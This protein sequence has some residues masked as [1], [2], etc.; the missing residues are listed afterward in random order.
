MFWRLK[1]NERTINEPAFRV[2]LPGEWIQE[3]S[4]A[5]NLWTYHAEGQREGLTISIMGDTQQMS[6]DELS[7]TLHRLVEM[8]RHTE[9]QVPGVTGVTVS[10]ATFTELEGTLAARYVGTQPSAQRRFYCLVLG[11]HRTFYFFYYGAIGMP[12]TESEA[13]ARHI[14]NSIAVPR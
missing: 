14:F 1:P 12:G 10:E 8:R 7:S 5:P 4:T 11:S 6:Q 2:T 3:P 9:T 13:R